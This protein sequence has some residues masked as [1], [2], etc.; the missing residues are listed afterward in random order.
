MGVAVNKSTATICVMLPLLGR[1]VDAV[2]VAV[3]ERNWAET[4]DTFLGVVRQDG[5]GS[6]C[7]GRTVDAVPKV[8]AIVS[9]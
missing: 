5:L 1:G 2:G 8:S 9:D 3:Y 7:F 6:C 4:I